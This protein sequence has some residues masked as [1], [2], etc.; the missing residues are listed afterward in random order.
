MH[1]L[2]IAMNIVEIAEEESK[3]A[4]T[5]T[6]SE[7]E[8]EIG[9]M[10][11]VVIEA[12]DFALAEAKKNSVLSNAK[13]IINNIHAKARCLDCNHE[14][15]VEELFT[16]CPKCNSFRNEVI[17]GKELKVKRLIAQ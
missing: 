13:F 9:T 5:S 2:S 7:I 17:Q 11:G 12:L 6:V 14:F 3:K 8:L 1:E 15:D 10:A 16:P 4:G